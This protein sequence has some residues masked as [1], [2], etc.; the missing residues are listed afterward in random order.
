MKFTVIDYGLIFGGTLPE[1][2]FQYFPDDLALGGPK[3][4]D[5][6]PLYVSTCKRNI[7]SL[8]IDITKMGSDS[9]WKSMKIISVL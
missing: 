9:F 1:D 6:C 4:A 5:N 7:I 3:Q 2:R 8:T